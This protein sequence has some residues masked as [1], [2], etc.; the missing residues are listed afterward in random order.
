MVNTFDKK[1]YDIEYSRQK[2]EKDKANE[3]RA[4]LRSQG[5]HNLEDIEDEELGKAYTAPTAN[6][7]RID[8]AKMMT[9]EEL[10]EA[11]KHTQ[12]ILDMGAKLPD[13]VQDM[14]Y[15]RQREQGVETDE[16][17]AEDP[18]LPEYARQLINKFNTGVKLN[19]SDF[20]DRA[21]E[22]AP[23]NEIEISG[24]TFYVDEM[25]S[26]V[27]SLMESDSTME[28]VPNGWRFMMEYLSMVDTVKSMTNEQA[29]VVFG[30]MDT[31]Q[32]MINF[33][34]YDSENDGQNLAG[35]VSLRQNIEYALTF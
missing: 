1:Q 23:D 33:T 8:M 35:M 24:N 5:F 26:E 10:T 22:G 3:V 15:V 9:D 6:Q 7:L 20:E 28:A 14:L 34:N 25:L 13:D 18:F 16:R 11:P 30:M 4:Y 31:G 2:R 19:M 27:V 21:R 12:K 29:I 17:Q 32:F